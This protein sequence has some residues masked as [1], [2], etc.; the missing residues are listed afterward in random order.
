MTLYGKQ[1]ILCVYIS[2]SCMFEGTREQLAEHLEQ[3]KFEGLKVNTHIC[4][5]PPPPPPSHL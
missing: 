3:C 2:V 1:V 4:L 5:P